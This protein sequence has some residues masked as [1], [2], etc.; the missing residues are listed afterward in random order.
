MPNNISSKPPFAGKKPFRE[1]REGRPAFP[2]RGDRPATG[3]FGK[4]FRENPKGSGEGGTETFKRRAPSEGARGDFRAARDQRPSYGKRDSFS[5]RDRGS[6]ERRPFGRDRFRPSGSTE[7]GERP[8]R[9]DSSFEPRKKTWGRLE[10]RGNS[11][12]PREGSS[13]RKEGSS[14][15][16]P[17][18]DGS[19][20]R[21]SR[22]DS[23]FEPRKKT[24]GGS[25]GRGHFG[26][27]R[28]GGRA[29]FREEGS[30]SWRPFREGPRS[31]RRDSSFEGNRGF[32]S[33]P[34][35]SFRARSESKERPARPYGEKESRF[36][37]GPRERRDFSDRFPARSSSGPE[38][39]SF[40]QVRSFPRKER[41]EPKNA[42]DPT[43][44]S[45]E[46]IISQPQSG[47]EDHLS[48]LTGQESSQIQD[49]ETFT[50]EADICTSELS[51]IHDDIPPQE[52]DEDVQESF[53]SDPPESLLK[54]KW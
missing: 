30:S 39:D 42:Q 3:R 32:D 25:E 12:K 9:A 36:S 51:D 22:P 20:P 14:S 1:K 18:R 54:L 47:Q 44:T 13:F 21:S 26:K 43:L 41:V 23:S 10:G 15:W 19:G 16:R 29:S 46:I 24:W 53:F 35:G 49:Q 50:E 48:L 4:P 2:A 27:P 40:P 17:V 6:A 31:P 45:E 38:Q 28:E 8:S 5:E 37:R 7:G 33:Q 34:R 52:S 11:G